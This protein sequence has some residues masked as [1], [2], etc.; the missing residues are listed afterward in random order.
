[1]ARDK[2]IEYDSTAA[3]NTVIGDV[4]TSETMLP[5]EVND[6][7]REIASHLKAFADGT[8]GIN[9]LSL[10]DDT[11]TNA[12]KFQAPASVTGTVTF[13]LPDGDGTSGQA[14]IT[15]GSGVLS[16]GD[17]GGGGGGGGSNV[18]TLF[19]FTATAGQ[20][21]FTGADDNSATLAYTAG[22]IVV[23]MNGVT[24]DPSDFTAGNGT[25]LVLASGAAVGD[26]V[27]I[28]AFSTFSVAD[29]VAA[30]TGG[31]FSGNITAPSF[32]TTAT[33][34]HTAAFRTNEQTVNQ[35]TTIDADENA[36]AIGPLSIDP[37]A[38][39]TVSGNLTI[40]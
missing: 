30:S 5:S 36:L 40:L 26:I 14:I 7:I 23:T 35:N 32:Q 19:E 3:S 11:D 21:T 13:T 38:S 20:A 12:I 15:D 24:L 31:T 25:S 1:M 37:A 18:F 6:A 39:I 17:A 9:A 10:T 27:N 28:Y 34:M 16:W 22:S 8:S 29:T 33:K 4:N 2:L